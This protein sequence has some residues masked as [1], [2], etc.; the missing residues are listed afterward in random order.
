M[1]SLKPGTKLLTA[2]DIARILN[3]SKSYAY[4]LMKEGNIPCV[5]IGRSRRVRPQDLHQYI[6]DNLS[7][8]NTGILN[9]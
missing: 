6:H 4:Q 3:I 8:K 5:H 1:N 9:I 7:S 2:M